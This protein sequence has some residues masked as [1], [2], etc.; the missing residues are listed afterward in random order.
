MV[1]AILQETGEISV[2][3]CPRKAGRVVNVVCV[4]RLSGEGGVGWSL[5]CGRAGS[6]REL[7]CVLD[8]ECDAPAGI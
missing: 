1:R 8:R 5:S 2:E 7:C 3:I 6:V 4:C